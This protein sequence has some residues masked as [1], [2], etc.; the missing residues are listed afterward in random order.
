MWVCVCVQC[1]CVILTCPWLHVRVQFV[2]QE[3]TSDTS[4]LL[5]FDMLSSK[6]YRCSGREWQEWGWGTAGGDG[7]QYTALLKDA[8]ASSSTVAQS[9]SDDDEEERQT[10]KPEEDDEDAE[11]ED[12]ETTTPA[13]ER[14]GK[15]R[16]MKCMPG[17]QESLI[18]KLHKSL[19][20][21]LC[22][23]RY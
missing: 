21:K 14:N 13:A 8:A 4:G 11:D 16:K 23:Y 17:K 5:Y 9:E 22:L 10:S 15:K 2:P 7:F 20:V 6:M 12:V 19:A 3:C 18:V 1:V